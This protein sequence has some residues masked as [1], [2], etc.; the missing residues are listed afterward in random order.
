MHNIQVILYDAVTAGNNLCQTASASM[1]IVNGRF[2][3]QLPD[4][5]TAAVGANSSAW[6]DVLVDGSDTGRTKLGAVPYAV[7]ANHAASASSVT[8]P[9]AQQVVPS[10]LV[11]IFVASCPAGWVTCDGT[12]VCPDLRGAYLKGGTAFAPI[13]GS[14]THSHGVGTYSVASAGDHVHVALLDMFESGGN[15]FVYTQETTLPFWAATNV[16]QGTINI[17]PGSSPANATQNGTLTS[18]NG[19]HTHA[20]AGTSAIAN[21]EPVNATVVLCMKQ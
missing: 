12:G 16:M 19:A 7:E 14:N 2:A 1:N 4:T 10:G 5:C 21:H 9:Q 20:L 11:G 15:G 8:G 3:V 18:S 17:S 13:T 6:V